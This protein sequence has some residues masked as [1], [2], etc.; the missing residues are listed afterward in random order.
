MESL[1]MKAEKVGEEINEK[2]RHKTVCVICGNKTKLDKYG[3]SY[4]PR[5]W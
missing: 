2:L 3:E 5:C 1:V 4:C